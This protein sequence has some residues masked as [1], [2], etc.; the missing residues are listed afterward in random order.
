VLLAVILAG[1][2]IEGGWVSLTVTVKLQAGPAVVE[3]AT[4]VVPIGKELPDAGAQTTAPQVPVVIG[5]A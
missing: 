5:A 3:Q 1:H 2:V 4:V